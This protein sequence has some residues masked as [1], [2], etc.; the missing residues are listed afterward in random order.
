MRNKPTFLDLTD[1]YFVT[2]SDMTLDLKKMLTKV[3]FF[4]FELWRRNKYHDH[5]VFAQN[6]YL[7]N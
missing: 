1:F 5:F 2:L 7:L 4:I 3:N 6:Q